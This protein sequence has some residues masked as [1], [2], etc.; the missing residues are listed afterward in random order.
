M[1]RP[2]SLESTRHPTWELVDML[3]DLISGTSLK[4]IQS[5]NLVPSLYDYIG[6][7]YTGSNLTGVVYKIGGTTVATLTLAYTG[8]RL[9]SVTKT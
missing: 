5:N 3:D 6:L 4:V 7:A 2:T 9:D 8:S 1:V